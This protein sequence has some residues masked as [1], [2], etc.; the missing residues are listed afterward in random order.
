MTR[1]HRPPR[2]RPNYGAALRIAHLVLALLHRPGG[3]DTADLRRLLGISERTLLRY[4]AACRTGLFG[5]DGA[6]LIQRSD[7]R[8]VIVADY[9]PPPPI[10]A[11]ADEHNPWAQPGRRAA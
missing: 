3:L 4:V 10:F 8:F 5:V 2:R 7:G 11:A 9:A 1:P 6:P